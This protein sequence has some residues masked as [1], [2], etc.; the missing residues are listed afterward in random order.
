VPGGALPNPDIPGLS[1]WAY[2]KDV[3]GA[4]NA[5]DTDPNVIGLLAW[6]KAE[7]G[8]AKFNPMNTTQH[9]QGSTDYNS[10]G[11][12]SYKTWDD[13]VNA[14]VATLT[15]GRYGAVVDAIRGDRGPQAVAQAVGRSPWGT[16]GQLMGEVAAGWGNGK[17]AG[18]IQAI[19][20]GGSAVA[21]AGGGDLGSGIVDAGKS[22]LGFVTAPISWGE[23]L[24]KFLG[25]LLDRQ[26]WIRALEILGGLALGIGG[27]FLLGRI[28]VA[29]QAGGLVG[30]ALRS[31]R[32]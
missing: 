31:A 20:Y 14:T 18:V 24:A 5:P 27:L 10:A 1:R 8:S 11:V 32:S 25:K 9:A 13:G 3:L 23:A 17:G 15:N 29:E 4:L 12:Q 2:A 30:S 22:A 7:G 28:L 21:G 16:N 19:G 26:T 6:M